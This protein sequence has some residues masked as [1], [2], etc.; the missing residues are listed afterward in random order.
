MRRFVPIRRHGKGYR[1]SVLNYV[2]KNRHKVRNKYETVS[3]RLETLEV[4]EIGAVL[5]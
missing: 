4:K 3:S 2:L 1:E 5:E